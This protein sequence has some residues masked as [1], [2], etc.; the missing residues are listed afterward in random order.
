MIICRLC[1]RTSGNASTLQ[2]DCIMQPFGT[3]PH[4]HSIQ[5][6]CEKKSDWTAGGSTIESPYTTVNIYAKHLTFFPAYIV[7]YLPKEFF[8]H[9]CRYMYQKRGVHR[10]SLFTS[11]VAV[12]FRVADPDSKRIP[13]YLSCWIRIRIQVLNLLLILKKGLKTF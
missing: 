10:S 9:V 6:F 2:W 13:I 8:F 3:H 4:V 7:K 12:I 11:C 5:F 1:M